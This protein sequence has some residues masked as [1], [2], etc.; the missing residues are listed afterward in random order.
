[1]CGGNGRFGVPKSIAYEKK[2]THSSGEGIIIDAGNRGHGPELAA[3]KP[4]DA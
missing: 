3:S 2:C 4:C 1:M